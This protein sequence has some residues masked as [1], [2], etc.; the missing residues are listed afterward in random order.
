MMPDE[1][2][3]TALIGLGV[4]EVVIVLMWKWWR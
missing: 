1:A 2:L 4:V 3:W